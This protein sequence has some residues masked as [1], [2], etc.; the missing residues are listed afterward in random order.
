MAISSVT[1]SLL[2]SR[3]RDAD[4]CV[5]RGD[6]KAATQILVEIVQQD[7]DRIET[8][9]KI[10]A[11]RRA[12]GNLQG[13]IAAATDALRSDP[14][15]LVA[16]LSRARLIEASG[17][18]KEAGRAYTLALSQ[19]PE[20]D[21]V[22]ATLIPLI[23]HARTASANYQNNVAAIWDSSINSLDGLSEAVRRRL[24]RFKTN[25]LRHTRVYHSEPSHYHYPGLIEH[26][27]HDRDLFPWLREFETATPAI[28]HELRRLIE[29]DQAAK[30]PYIQYSADTPVRQWASLN[31]SLDWTAFHLLKG[32]QRVS[33]NADQCPE[34]MLAIAKINQP[35][36]K[37]RSPNAMFSL[38]K[39]QTRI[40]P[41]TGISNTRLVCHLP[42]IVPDNCW[43]RVGAQRREWH[44]GEAF[45]FDDTIEHEAA[46]DSDYPRVVL[47][48]DIWHPGLDSMERRA[49]ERV[50]EADED[51]NG[52]PL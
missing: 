51:H 23:N 17:D 24:E 6:I 13:A 19:V 41:H 8:W 28:Q 37:G 1:P 40:P 31:H 50:M 47:I 9:L 48:I 15:H 5:E 21:A 35:Q 18:A 45:V 34:T 3:E 33:Q 43:F 32:G 14:L 44:I 38:L 2:D 26:E 49:I 16:L 4:G 30:E 22:Q 25:A 46:N 36:M 12:A 29:K 39:P 52:A 7:A 42:L 11:L 27:F 10:A 20:G